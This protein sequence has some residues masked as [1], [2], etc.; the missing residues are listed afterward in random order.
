MATAGTT[1]IVFLKQDPFFRTNDCMTA[2]TDAPPPA[3]DSEID[4]S[5]K[6]YTMDSL[7]DCRTASWFSV[8][9]ILV[10][11]DALHTTLTTFLEGLTY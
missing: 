9:S 5:G 10:E 11:K 2:R 8:A 6:S 4:S 1:E 7:L 3:L